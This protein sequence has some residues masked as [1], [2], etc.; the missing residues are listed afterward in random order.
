[1]IDPWR[2]SRQARPVKHKVCLGG[3]NDPNRRVME[4]LGASLIQEAAHC[5]E[6][7]L[8]FDQTIFGHDF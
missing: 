6:S 5:I 4:L 1:M 8:S 7:D 2:D 3:H